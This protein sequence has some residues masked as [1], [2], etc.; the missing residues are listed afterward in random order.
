MLTVALISA[1]GAAG[2]PRSPSRLTAEE[3]VARNVEARGGLDKWRSIRTMIWT[4]QLESDTAPA[5]TIAFTL[6]QKRPNKTR[7]EITGVGARTMRIFDGIHGYKVRARREGGPD[8]QPY[9]IEEIRFARD[10]QA[11][12]GPLIDYAA[13]GSRV[14]LV[15]LERLGDQPAYHLQVTYTSGEHQDVWLDAHT[16]LELRADRPAYSTAASGGAIAVPAGSVPVF[17]REFKEFDG[18]MLPTVIEIGGSDK[19]TPDRMLIERVLIN[20]SIE[21]RIFE[22]PG[23]PRRDAF[24]VARGGGARE[25]S[26]P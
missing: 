20:A 18:I 12:D 22:R 16:F 5:P 7:F 14:A 2:A 1:V 24:G 13:K 9:S 8:I 3:I 21:D 10:S 25:A 6:E 4:G 19:R 23:T 26:P 11:I 17:Y 15:G